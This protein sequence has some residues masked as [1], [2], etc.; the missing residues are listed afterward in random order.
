VTSDRAVRIPRSS[1]ALAPAARAKTPSDADY[2]SNRAGTQRAVRLSVCF[3]VGVA[4]LYGL[5]FALERSAPGSGSS[6]ATNGFDLLSA[7]AGVMA[8]VGVLFA[9]S[10]APRGVEL[11]AD[12]TIVVGRWG[13]RRSFPP[14]AAAKVRELRRFPKSF[15]AD[16]PVVVIEIAAASG[17]RTTFLIED[18]ILGPPEAAGPA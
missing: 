17:R 8:L 14:V 18:G 9:L 11:G 10:W 1:P 13:R 16:A 15:L 2:R 3:V 7:L 6:G 12:A 5:F 4:V